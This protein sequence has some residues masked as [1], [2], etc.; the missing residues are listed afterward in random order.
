MEPLAAVVQL[1]GERKSPEN[2]KRLR[3]R[4]HAANAVQPEMYKSSTALPRLLRNT[5]IRKLADGCAD[6]LYL[7]A[8]L[9][10]FGDLNLLFFRKP[11]RVYETIY[12]NRLTTCVRNS[13]LRV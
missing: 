4:A 1:E 11:Y 3:S 9:V 2:T 5:C 7:I 6:A 10:A 12:W 13:I 8:L